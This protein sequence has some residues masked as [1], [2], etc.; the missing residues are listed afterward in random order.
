M[1]RPHRILLRVSVEISDTQKDEILVSERDVEDAEGPTTLAAD[2]CRKHNLDP[3]KVLSPLKDHILSNI[4]ALGDATNRINGKKGSPNEARQTKPKASPSQPKT[5]ASLTNGASRASTAGAVPK[6][7]IS[8]SS[9]H[10]GTLT[11]RPTSSTSSRAKTPQTNGVRE[12]TGV[13][14]KERPSTYSE[15]RSN[16]P[17]RVAPKSTPRSRPSSTP[18][19]SNSTPRLSNTPRT[20]STPRPSSTTARSRSSREARGVTVTQESK[21]DDAKDEKKVAETVQLDLADM[22]RTAGSDCVKREKSSNSLHGKSER[23][24]WSARGTPDRGQ[25]SARSKSGTGNLSAR[26]LPVSAQGSRSAKGSMS[27]RQ[28]P[29][30]RRNVFDKLY[31]DAAV[32]SVK[33]DTLRAGFIAAMDKERNAQISAT[34]TRNTCGQR[35]RARSTDAGFRLYVDAQKRKEKFD[36]LRE[37]QEK[38]LERKEMEE[39]TL[40]PH[41]NESQKR[42]LGL[43]SRFSGDIA[44][45]RRSSAKM[46]RIRQ[47]QEEKEMGGCT[48]HPCIDER[49]QAMMQHRLSR[50]KITGSLHEHLYDDAKRREGRY[51]DYQQNVASEETFFPDIGAGHFRP[52]NDDTQQDFLMRLAYSKTNSFRKSAPDPHALFRPKTGRA[53]N[54]ARN[55]EGLP[56]GHF[57]YND[58]QEKSDR[59]ERKV[60][61]AR[62][63]PKTRAMTKAMSSSSKQAFD[64]AKRR[65]YEQIF[66]ALTNGGDELVPTEAR[67]DGIDPDI[68]EFVNPIIGF[69]LEDNTTL[70]F[71]DFCIAMDYAIE[72]S[73]T[74]VAHLFVDHARQKPV[75]EPTFTPRVNKN[76]EELAKKRPRDVSLPLHAQ[77]CAENE[78]YMASRQRKVQERAEELMRECT[79]QPNCEGGSRPRTPVASINL[80]RSDPCLAGARPRPLD[81]LAQ[82]DAAE[83]AVRRCRDVVEK[84]KQSVQNI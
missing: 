65:K 35:A 61:S 9:S 32:K 15:K 18:R 43:P 13:P 16:T 83:A 30:L 54:S 77:L 64:S 63:Q 74:P 36:A 60:Q 51:A 80:S 23:S 66:D 29:T 1:A 19:V 84:A 52:P 81:Y 7:R 58:A 62:E 4:S 53:P 31:A 10:P 20:S 38:L 33:M 82:V 22:K 27:A 45:R 49:S 14:A 28:I 42:V 46:E 5:K 40:T 78:A 37:K 69:A 56:I 70:S 2:F 55:S 3:I 26:T 73:V 47:E 8:S 44:T 59:L 71:G 25:W 67:L 57:L 39:V 21:E 12:S 24:S 11:T 34:T 6:S 79:F 50:L 72:T 48:F 17:N 76:S 68:A 75:D 41:I